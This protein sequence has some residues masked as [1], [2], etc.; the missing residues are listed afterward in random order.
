MVYMAAALVAATL[1]VN[2]LADALGDVPYF[3]SKAPIADAQ[4]EQRVLPLHD[5]D[6]HWCDGCYYLNVRH[7]GESSPLWC[8]QAP[9]TCAGLG[10][11]VGQ[12]T[13]TRRTCTCPT[14]AFVNSL[15]DVTSTATSCTLPMSPAASLSIAV[16]NLELANAFVNEIGLAAP[17]TASTTLTTG[18]TTSTTTMDTSCA[19]PLPCLDEGVDLILNMTVK[20]DRCANVCP[21][22][23]V[24]VRTAHTANHAVNALPTAIVDVIGLAAWGTATTTL[25]MED[26]MSTATSRSSPMSPAAPVRMA[27]AVSYV[28]VHGLAAPTT[29]RTTL[30]T[31]GTTSTAT[32]DTNCAQP[33]PCLNE[34]VCLNLNMAL[35]ADRCSIDHFLEIVDVRTAHIANHAVNALPTAV[36]HVIGLAARRTMT[37]LTTEWTTSTTTTELNLGLTVPSLN[38]SNDEDSQRMMDAHLPDR[39]SLVEV[40]EASDVAWFMERQG[41]SRAP[42]DPREP[43]EP[44]G[45]PPRAHGRGREPQGRDR[46]RTQHRSNEG[47]GSSTDHRHT[48]APWRRYM[49]R[50]RRLAGPQTVTR[51]RGTLSSRQ[52]S[53]ATCAAE[54]TRSAEEQ[55]QRSRTRRKRMRTTWPTWMSLH[56]CGVLYWAWWTSMQCLRMVGVLPPLWW[57]ATLATVSSR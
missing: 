21:L 1:F 52:R 12:A 17:T 30:A 32:K 54:A 20:A 6:V 47:A 33:L 19:L 18:W 28:N 24:D 46:S 3:N 36:V 7:F 26:E 16:V 55:S 41:R 10:W 8:T 15:E 14:T 31:G 5:H 38:E 13:L 4:P 49:T 23:I 35:R 50:T 40:D 43:R 22:D 48:D 56:M 27:Q 11:S 29:A 44:D 37:T 57:K 34:S 42:R 53:D 39:S 45:P 2:F 25:S 51:E 9:G